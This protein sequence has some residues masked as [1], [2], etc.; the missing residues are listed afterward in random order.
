M[1]VSNESANAM[2]IFATLSNNAINGEIYSQILCTNV[3]PFN[4]QHHSDG[5]YYLWPDLAS[6]HYSWDALQVLQENC[7]QFLPVEKNLRAIASLC[8][9]EEYWAVLKKAMYDGGWEAK[10]F[11][12][13][14]D[15]IKHKACKVPVKTIKKTVPTCQ[16]SNAQLQMMGN[17]SLAC[18]HQICW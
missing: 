8:P 9:M 1:K 7:I 10:S 3:V 17:S 14:R 6:A 5:S 15:W 12:K 16:R 13:L 4:Q 2:R 11:D 18:L